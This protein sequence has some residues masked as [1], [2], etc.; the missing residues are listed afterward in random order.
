LGTAQVIAATLVGA[1]HPHIRD[2]RF[3]TV[4]IDE[5]AQGLEPACWIPIL[6]ADR[7][8]LAGDHCQL[9]PT[10]KSDEKESRQL[11]NTLFE[12]LVKK[13]PDAVS[14]LDTQYRMN[15][16]IMTYPSITIYDGMLKAAPSAAEWRLMDDTQPIVFIDT[17]GAGFEEREEEG[18]LSNKEEADFLVNHLVGLM[19]Q[20]EGV[21]SEAMLPSVGVITP[22]RGQANRLK[23]LLS[24]VEGVSG[25]DLQVSTVDGFQGQEKD[26]IYISLVRSNAGGNIGFL[27]DVRRI[28]VALTRAKKKLIVI[29]DSSTIGQHAFYKGF[30]DYVESVNGYHSVWEW[31]I[32]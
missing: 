25:I 32:V 31:D 18:A 9:P 21:Y 1:N 11:F 14:F 7:L 5:A 17:A 26:I 30:L 13:Y 10:I 19:T 23:T 3:H 12:K 16:Q 24:N 8:L 6:K 27:S 2:R 29:G 20:L 4:V 28:N 22:Y 15:S